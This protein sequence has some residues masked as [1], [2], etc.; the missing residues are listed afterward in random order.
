MAYLLPHGWTLGT[1][2]AVQAAVERARIQSDGSGWMG[3]AEVEL[4]KACNRTLFSAWK[5]RPSPD[6]KLAYDDFGEVT[7]SAIGAGVLS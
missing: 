5:E 7:L 3:R 6:G 1:E 2:P 4:V